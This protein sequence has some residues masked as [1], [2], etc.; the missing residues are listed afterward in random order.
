MSGD[1]VQHAAAPLEM[2]SLSSGGAALIIVPGR[3][4][5]ILGH[6]CFEPVSATQNI[7]IAKVG[8]EQV[9]QA[10]GRFSS[11]QIEGDLTFCA[12]P[13]SDF[14]GSAFVDQSGIAEYAL[15]EG[16]PVEL[17]ALPDERFSNVIHS[18]V[19]V[20][21]SNAST[22]ADTGEAASFPGEGRA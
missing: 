16:V 12:E 4:A 15:V 14:E 18:S 8:A 19:P 6:I 22:V 20:V 17:D 1:A 5:D 13:V 11:L 10:E 2:R 3:G 7:Q 21:V 9:E